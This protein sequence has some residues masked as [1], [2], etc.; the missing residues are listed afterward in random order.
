MLV[1][2]DVDLIFPAEFARK[3]C[4]NRKI[5]EANQNLAKRSKN[6]SALLT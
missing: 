2:E 6:K 3:K 4:Q 1:S 5:A